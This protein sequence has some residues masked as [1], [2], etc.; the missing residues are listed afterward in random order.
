MKLLP[1][2]YYESIFTINYKKLS[3]K[4]A[5]IYDL[6][7]TFDI[8]IATNGF[9][10][11]LG[12]YPFIKGILRLSL[13]PCTLRVKKLLKDYKKEDLV[14]IG[15]QLFTDIKMAKKLGIT[16]VLVKPLTDQDLL[17]TKINRI[18]ERR[19]FEKLEKKG[20]FTLNEFDR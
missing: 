8:F 13:K 17:N 1:D 10:R 9:G 14:M 7:N 11:N 18:K 4:K 2:Y 15:D 12:E 6:D 3:S 5:L 20:V 16:S 19:Y